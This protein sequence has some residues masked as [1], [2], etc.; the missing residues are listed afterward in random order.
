MLKTILYQKECVHLRKFIKT[1]N[2]RTKYYTAE[3][4]ADFLDRLLFRVCKN[5]FIIMDNIKELRC[6]LIIFQRHTDHFSTKPLMH[7][8]NRAFAAIGI[9]E[10]ISFACMA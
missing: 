8:T 9:G 10:C 6:K 2:Y 7:A 3:K 1:Y 4:V 5:T